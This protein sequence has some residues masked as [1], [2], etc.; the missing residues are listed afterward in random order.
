MITIKTSILINSTE[1]LQ[2]LAQSELKARIAWQVARTLKAVEEEL[3]TFNE[4]RMTLIHKY[5]EK[6]DDGTLV[7][8]ENNNCKIVPEQMPLFNKELTDLL[9]EEISINANKISI[10]DIENLDFA[11]SEMAI[12]EYFIDFGEE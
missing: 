10:Y 6:N 3:Q 8:D 12:L 11:P 1:V 5:G 9:N 4:T 7:T 2:K